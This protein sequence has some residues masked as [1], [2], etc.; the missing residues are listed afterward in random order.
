MTDTNQK[1]LGSTLW[2]IA[3]QLRGA[4]DADDFR[5]SMLSF[6]FPRCLSE[7]RVAAALCP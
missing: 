5:D 4:M 3:D 2:S 6:G 7:S 1:Q